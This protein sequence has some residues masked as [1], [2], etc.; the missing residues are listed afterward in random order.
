VVSGRL[1]DEGLERPRGAVGRLEL[2]ATDGPRRF[3]RVGGAFLGARLAPE[4]IEIVDL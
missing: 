4:D 1:R 3:A 2:L